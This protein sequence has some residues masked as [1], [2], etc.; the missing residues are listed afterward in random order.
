MNSDLLDLEKEWTSELK[1]RGF[2][3]E[4]PLGESDHTRISAM[5]GK[6]LR[7]LGP[8]KLPTVLVVLAVN[9]AYLYYD[10]EGFWR[11]FLDCLGLSRDWQSWL[12]PQIE[13]RLKTLKKQRRKVDGFR[14]VGAILEQCGITRRYIP[15]YSNILN[16]CYHSFGGWEGVKTI[17]YGRFKASIPKFG[18]SSYLITYLEDKSGWEFTRDVAACL[19]QSQR[20]MITTTELEALPGFR[21]GFWKALLENLNHPK[22][23]KATGVPMPRFCYDP[24]YGNFK[25]AFDVDYAKRGQYRFEGRQVYDYQLIVGNSDLKPTYRVEIQRRADHGESWETFFLEGWDPTESDHALFHEERGFVGHRRHLRPGR[26]FLFTTFGVDVPTNIIVAGPDLISVRGNAY[27]CWVID[28]NSPD[29][30]DFLGRTLQENRQEKLLSWEN[31][32]TKLEGARDVSD[33]FVAKIPRIICDHSTVSGKV[34]RLF[35]DP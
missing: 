18:L 8:F 25:I 5:L 27:K 13:K 1:D 21:S 31:E 34:F 22:A 12:A 33:V 16:H 23:R 7:E 6:E 35:M 2:I 19:S 24:D 32:R 9:A 30:V 3:G 4:L 26:F 29:D 10:D 11:H 28:I 14:Y 17:D 15:S 20:G